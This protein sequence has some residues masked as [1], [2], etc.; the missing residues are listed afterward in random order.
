MGT[1]IFVEQLKTI[2]KQ[3]YVPINEANMT[4]SSFI[5]LRI[6]VVTEHKQNKQ[7]NKMKLLKVYSD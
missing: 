6:V 2:N 7:I 1:Q 3:A 4:Y 5:S